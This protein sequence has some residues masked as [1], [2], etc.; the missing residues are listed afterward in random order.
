MCG[1]LLLSLITGKW[2][3]KQ[4]PHAQPDATVT[5]PKKVI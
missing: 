3:Y 5:V 2:A 1:K 4:A